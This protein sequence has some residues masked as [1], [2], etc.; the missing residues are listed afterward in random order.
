MKDICYV[1]RVGA[2]FKGCE[3][4]NKAAAFLRKYLGCSNRLEY[5]GGGYEG[6]C[7][8]LYESNKDSNWHRIE[9]TWGEIPSTWAIE[10]KETIVIN[11]NVKLLGKL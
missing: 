8:Y 10:N 1:V 7:I 3:T 2:D 5:G 6:G 11:L 4:S 9:R